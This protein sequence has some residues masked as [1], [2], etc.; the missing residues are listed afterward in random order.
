MSLAILLF[1]SCGEKKDSLTNDSK[2][3]PF[4]TE[5]LL[6]EIEAEQKP[7]TEKLKKLTPLSSTD[8]D[9]WMPV[10]L[11]DLNRVTY[12]TNALPTSFTYVTIARFKNSNPNI[13]LDITILDGAGRMGSVAITPFLD[14]ERIT[15]ETSTD[16][17]FQKTVTKNGK[18]Y[19]QKYSKEDDTYILQFTVNDR[20]MVII[21]TQNMTEEALWEYTSQFH[22][23]SLPS[24]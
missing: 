5:K 17:G 23:E 18:V 10:K 21:E 2:E 14:L 6:D 16:G 13:K 22:F 7:V 8:M 9:A 19:F 4:I 15:R 24:I 12:K 1:S 3:K 11:G 20:F